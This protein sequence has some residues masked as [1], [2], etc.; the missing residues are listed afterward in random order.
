MQKNMVYLTSSVCELQK[1]RS[2]K[3]KV[4]DDDDKVRPS[5]LELSDVS[6][7]GNG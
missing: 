2:K 4:P 5:H 7:D 3:R 6:E 1:K